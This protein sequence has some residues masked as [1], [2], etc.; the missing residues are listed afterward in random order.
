MRF[1]SSHFA[2]IVMCILVVRARADEVRSIDQASIGSF[3]ST[4]ADTSPTTASIVGSVQT[5]TAGVAESA[6]G[7]AKE[8]VDWSGSIAPAIAGAGS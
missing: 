4:V 1:S 3:H 2:V 5:T 8:Q 6:Y 7:R